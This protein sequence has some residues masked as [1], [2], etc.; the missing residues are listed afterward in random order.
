VNGDE[1]GAEAL[2]D[3]PSFIPKR[4]I[5]KGHIVAMEEGEAIILILEIEGGPEARGHLIYETKE[6]TIVAGT[7]GKRFELQTQALVPVFAN[8]SLSSTVLLIQ[9]P[10]PHLPLG[11]EK[12]IIDL[13]L[14]IATVDGKDTISRPDPQL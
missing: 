6:A 14:E 8:S 10:D 4:E 12:A 9:N 13:I 11:Q 2:S 3:D 5:G 1:E 7:D